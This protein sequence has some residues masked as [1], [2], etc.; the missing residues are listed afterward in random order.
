MRNILTNTRTNRNLAEKC[1]N[2]SFSKI[3]LAQCI[4]HLVVREVDSGILFIY[5]CVPTA[6]YLSRL[7]LRQSEK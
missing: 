1:E 6:T 7:V 2:C 4:K 5:T 3:V